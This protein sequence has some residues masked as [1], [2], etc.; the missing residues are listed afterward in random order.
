MSKLSPSNDLT[1]RLSFNVCSLLN[2]GF[3]DKSKMETETKGR[4]CSDTPNISPY[5]VVARSVT[6]DNT[7]NV[8]EEKDK[9]A[10]STKEH[11]SEL[12][13]EGNFRQDQET[14]IKDRT[15]D[16]KLSARCS[17]FVTSEAYLKMNVT[18][19]GSVTEPRA[20]ENVAFLH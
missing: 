7:K 11:V 13:T 12:N 10:A 4:R 16:L 15:V 20:E 2:K 6:Y 19:V 3:L 9:T 5:E 18:L 17:T 14:Q 1:N 8:Y